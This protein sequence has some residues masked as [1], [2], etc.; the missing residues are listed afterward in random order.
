MSVPEGASLFQALVLALWKFQGFLAGELFVNLLAAIEER[1]VGEL[2]AREPGR[3]RDKGYGQRQWR[4]PFGRISYRLRK[5]KDL[6]TGKVFSPLREAVGIPE[7]VRWCEETLL[8]GYRLGVLQSFRKSA[9]TVA[10][11]APTGEGPNHRTLHRRFQ[12]FAAAHLDPVPD[13]RHTRGPKPAAH[14]Q[15]DGT[16]LKLQNAGRD[17]GST[18]LR[19]VI[20]SRTPESKLE[21][22]DFSLG[23]S[24][25]EIA[26]RVRSKFPRL[27]RSLVHD[28]EEG[29]SSALAGPSTVCQRCLVH[30]RRNLKFALYSDGFKKA[31]QQWVKRD[32]AAIAGLRMCKEE[33]KALDS[34]DK[35]ALEQLLAESVKAAERLKE[36]LPESTYPATRSYVLGLVDQGLSYLHH[37][38]HGGEKLLLSTNRSENIM[39][40]LALRLKRIGRRWS[41]EGGLNMIAAVLTSSLHPERYDK[42]ERAARG[43]QL[44]HQVSILINDLAVSWAS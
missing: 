6:S 14:Q 10:R 32:F 42:I 25:D 11:N 9:R 36:R 12:D 8:P 43:E 18:D 2:R 33:L 4:L 39:G 37:L 17:A 30:G 15:A 40:Q 16:K 13:L 26:A 27:P 5:L 1:V 41:L 20:G 35:R 7:R 44:D 3:Y 23:K 21:V 22:L 28:G 19:I 38:L 29:I 34:A 24:W 31:D